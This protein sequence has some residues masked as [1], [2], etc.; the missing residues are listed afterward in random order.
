[1]KKIFKLQKLFR[2]EQQ[3]K[4]SSSLKEPIVKANCFNLSKRSS[5][6]LSSG[7]SFNG[8]SIKGGKV[9]NGNTTTQKVIVIAKSYNSGYNSKTKTKTTNKEAGA[10]A[11]KH[12]DYINKEDRN[13]ERSMILEQFDNV[14]ENEIYS[15]SKGEIEK[16]NIEDLELQI[17]KSLTNGK[18][19][20]SFSFEADD[21]ILDNKELL[22]DISKNNKLYIENEASTGKMKIHLKGNKESLALAL[23]KLNKA[24][25][26]NFKREDIKDIKTNVYNK[27]GEQLTY[28]NFNKKKKD[29][30]EKGIRG[31][32]S[33]EVSPKDNLSSE[34]LKAVV[35]N[36]IKKM[37]EAI[38]KKL[39]WNF[40]I[41]TNTEHTH[42]HIDVLDDKGA[43]KFTKP[44]LEAFKTLIA[45]SILEVEDYSKRM[46][47]E[48]KEVLKFENKEELNDIQKQKENDNKIMEKIEN[49][50]V[51]ILD[52]INGASS[53]R[54]LEKIEIYVSDSELREDFLKDISQKAKELANE[55]QN[56]NESGKF[57][58][59]SKRT[60]EE[61]NY[62]NERWKSERQTNE[63]KEKQ[64]QNQTTQSNKI[65]YGMSM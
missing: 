22:K 42:A 53:L 18:I 11:S 25:E 30:K 54:L 40:A 58:E 60:I 64:S 33:L 55:P 10:S 52:G 49:H 34:E 7:I 28:E 29:L 51:Y 20:K 24:E 19:E 37:E 15:F 2:E 36:T 32:L 46:K 39:D 56:E 26:K 43:L 48:N 21:K 12:L 9:S 14:L 5:N 44:Q 38:D 23:N 45:E 17:E 61:Y 35:E 50:D 4:S 31:V 65:S 13:E 63:E 8:G 6:T 41:H 16:I 1:M 27:H 47:E 59:L 62:R 3:I 57:L